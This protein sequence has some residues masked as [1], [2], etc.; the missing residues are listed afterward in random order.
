MSTNRVVVVTG[1]AGGIGLGIA[2]RFARDGYATAM[3][4]IADAELQREAD[5]LRA[6]GATVFTATADVTNRAQLDA[7]YADIRKALGPI[8]VVVANAGISPVVSFAEMTV[9]EWQQ[10]IDINLTGVFHTIQAALPDMAEAAWGRVVTISSH[11]GQS[12]APQRT[13]YSAA[14]GGVIGFTKGLARELAAQGITVNSIAPS[15]CV[16]PMMQRSIDAG[17]FPL[18]MI[19]PMIPIPRAGYPDDIAAAC[20]FLASDGASYITGQILG[21]NGGMYI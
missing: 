4:D 18:D 1:A 2:Q 20:T 12:G 19:I 10:M 6:E 16:T 9:D 21:V 7:A 15:V 14:K 11:A 8:T 13:H 5:T 17:E 3:L